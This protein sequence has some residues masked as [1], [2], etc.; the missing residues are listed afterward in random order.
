M[1]DITKPGII[2]I[3]KLYED[4]PQFTEDEF[5][6]AILKHLEVYKSNADFSAKFSKIAGGVIPTLFDMNGNVASQ[7]AANAIDHDFISNVQKL[8]KI[9][10]QKELA[11]LKEKRLEREKVEAEEKRAEAKGK[12]QQSLTKEQKEVLAFLAKK[13]ANPLSDVFEEK[14]SLL[15]DQC[16]DEAETFVSYVNEKQEAEERHYT[17][18]K[19]DIDKKIEDAKD[20]VQKSSYWSRR[21]AIEELD[22]LWEQKVQMDKAIDQARMAK[23]AYRECSQGDWGRGMLRATELFSSFV[24]TTTGSLINGAATF[25]GASVDYDRGTISKADFLVTA[26]LSSVQI[27]LECR[28][29]VKNA[30]AKISSSYQQ[31]LKKSLLDPKQ[32]QFK[33]LSQLAAN[34][35]HR[36]AANS[37]KLA[38]DSR[39]TGT[40]DAVGVHP[41]HQGPTMSSGGHRS[42][43]PPAATAYPSSS[44]TQ[45]HFDVPSASTHIHVGRVS[46]ETKNIP[47][48]PENIRNR[49]QFEKLKREYRQAMEKPNVT[50]PKLKERIDNLFRD[51]AKV[52]N[53]ST[54]A[55][56]RKEKKTG[57][58]VGDRYHK[59]KA[60][61]NAVFLENWL[62]TNKT[63][64]PS[65]KQAA[66][67]VLKDLLDALGRKY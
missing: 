43:L 2:D 61:D 23:Q 64:T 66:E 31:I 19:I 12:E 50:D 10:L 17:E 49:A 41:G 35:N 62:K 36:P 15:S 44:M 5:N 55:A 38:V 53:G 63:A 33:D 16:V 37:N 32:T 45:R 6:D 59:Q 21:E 3:E 22:S 24:P 65:D 57:R 14:S 29:V 20:T 11:K 8:Y 42:N 52:G 9:Q 58:M 4:N 1:S 28:S 46:V 40:L 54:S 51:N 34:S 26:A 56:L 47:L 39:A 60:E 18:L 13:T 48:N 7:T 30:A 25:A 27:G 67:N